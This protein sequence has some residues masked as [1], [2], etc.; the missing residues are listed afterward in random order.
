LR[1]IDGLTRGEGGDISGKITAKGSVK[2]VTS[3]GNISKPISADRSIGKVWALGDI[4]AGGSGETIL[5]AGDGSV[6]AYT[7]GNL[8]GA[9]DASTKVVA[10]VY[11]DTDLQLVKNV[12]AVE[13]AGW[14]RVALECKE[15]HETQL[16]ALGDIPL[17]GNAARNLTAV[18]WACI[19]G[20]IDLTAGNT[21]LVAARDIKDFTAQSSR[22]SKVV[23]IAYNDIQNVKINTAG[24]IWD[25]I[26]EAILGPDALTSVPSE[27]IL[28]AYGSVEGLDLEALT[29]IVVC[30]QETATGLN[31][32]VGEVAREGY[33]G[34]PQQLAAF[35]CSAT[36]A[37]LGAVQGAKILST[38]GT[39]KVEGAAVAGEFSG[40]NVSINASGDAAVTVTAR[41]SAAVAA[42]GTVSGGEITA[43]DG[44]AR[45]MATGNVSSP[46]KGKWGA[47]VHTWGSASGD[48]E[49]A[50]GSIS[51]ES[52]GDIT[53][54]LHAGNAVEAVGWGDLSAEVTADQGHATL[55]IAGDVS[56]DVTAGGDA[57]VEC[58]GDVLGNVTAGP[59]SLP[60]GAT[61]TWNAT[62]TAHGDV[63]GQVTSLHDAQV[64]AVYDV[65]SPQIV[66]RLGRATVIAGHDISTTN[67][68][69]HHSASLTAVHSVS[70]SVV[71]TT[72]PDHAG[73]AGHGEVTVTAGADV[74]T[75]VEAK[76][77]VRVAAGNEADA[78]I[79]VSADAKNVSL[80][81]GNR[82]SQARIEAPLGQVTVTAGGQSGTSSGIVVQN[83]S[84]GQ[85]E[86][87]AKPTAINVYA[88]GGLGQSTLAAQQSMYLF[89]LDQISGVDAQTTTAAGELVA[90]SKSDT[91]GTFSSSGS[92]NVF[93]GGQIQGDLA[94]GALPG[95]AADARVTSLQSINGSVVAGKDAILTA[96]Q[97]DGSVVAGQDVSLTTQASLG[98]T[99]TAG[100][101][102][103]VVILE[104]GCTRSVHATGDVTLVADGDINA[105][106]TAGGSAS[107]ISAQAVGGTIE[108]GA[109]AYVDATQAMNATVTA[110]QE[111]GVYGNTVAGNIRGTNARAVSASTIQGQIQGTQSAGAMALGAIRA[112][113]TAGTD[114]T[115]TTLADLEGNVTTT[116]GT[117]TAHVGNDLRGA[118]DAGTDVVLLVANRQQG[119][120]TA[121]E[122]VTGTIW[123]DS[124]GPV[125]AGVDVD[126]SVFGD[127][128]G[129]VSAGQNASLFVLE[130]VSGSIT[131]TGGS[132]PAW[133]PAAAAST[134]PC[135]ASTTTRSS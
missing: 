107:V 106:I 45:V 58:W 26:R 1:R 63:L 122:D 36:V 4:S 71:N 49:S 111:A 3:Y 110:G 113:V 55:Q 114:A 76:N 68:S 117:I 50:M 10:G 15:A 52:Y 81:A 98:A 87:S 40:K 121:G 82:V 7:W 99:V 11:G 84:V 59:A 21:R 132:A 126:L 54:K 124:A 85:D 125:Q 80:F 66:A 109:N 65:R 90:C 9:V 103:S 34:Q 123:G 79:T 67:V 73:I 130:D 41:D 37:A 92:L 75:T 29:N 13:V 96:P 78:T 43:L 53:G 104:G 100:D 2:S 134:S 74:Q 57:F 28:V 115:V 25:P 91:R 23:G 105:S 5:R 51:V 89:A 118:L 101:D 127:L 31:I 60:S 128:Q 47:A 112:T 62:V 33:S 20:K 120:V 56:K 70:Q 86:S 72:L 94:S 77:H 44:V 61:H 83:L 12:K 42:Q 116:T 27:I 16:W 14:S 88:L 69:S 8:Q 119:N 32:K 95:Q 108:A 17:I 131:A 48:V 93:A 6:A 133:P 97:I 24:S 22:G 129:G 30:A 39:I 18:S 64:H 35:T 135:G 46:V 19:S 38:Y 102:A